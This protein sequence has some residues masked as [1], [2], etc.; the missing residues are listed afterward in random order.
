MP[1]VENN[2][3]SKSCDD[4]RDAGIYKDAW[5]GEVGI[6]AKEGKMYFSSRRSPKMSGV[7]LP[8]MG[9]SFVVKWYDRSLDADAFVSFRVG[10]DGKAAGFTMRA[11]SPLT[12]FSFDFQDLDFVRIND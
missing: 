12:D 5:F 3:W 11:I 4:L 10:N 8:Y 1:G 6:R 9:N 7:L 2:V